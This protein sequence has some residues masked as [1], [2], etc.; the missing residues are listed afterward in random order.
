[1]N[2]LGIDKASINNGPGVRVVLWV[3]GCTVHCKGC[4]N[5]ESWSFN[6]GKP[7][8]D[9]AKKELFDALN[10][11]YI[12]GLTISGGHPL[13]KENLAEV[14][15]L[16]GLVKEYFPCKDI[17]LYTG[18]QLQYSNFNGKESTYFLV[19]G[20]EPIIASLSM[21]LSKCDVIVDGPYIEEQHDITL[22]FRG[23]KNQRIID[24]YQTI[25][26]GKIITLQN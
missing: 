14:Y 22:K 1:M 2:Y 5:P 12:R 17:W 18:Y 24:V 26:E 3:S 19:D 23:S 21:L 6:A 9:I 13:E 8:D 15:R 11:P 16:I 10:K 4:Q 7:F 25:L 20:D